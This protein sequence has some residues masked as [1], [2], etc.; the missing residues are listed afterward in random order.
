MGMERF[1]RLPSI[2]FLERVF[3]TIQECHGVW[4]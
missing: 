4:K 1:G 3:L 2:L